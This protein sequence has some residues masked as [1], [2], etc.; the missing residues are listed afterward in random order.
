[1]FFVLTTF[2]NLVKLLN[3]YDSFENEMMH[4]KCYRIFFVTF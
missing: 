4:K 3:N 2:K 1:M